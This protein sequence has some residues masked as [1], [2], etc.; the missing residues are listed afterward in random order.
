MKQEDMLLTIYLYVYLNSIWSCFCALINIQRSSTISTC[1]SKIVDWLINDDG[2]PP[3]MLP[4][5]FHEYLILDYETKLQIVT[6]A[7]AQSNHT[8][9]VVHITNPERIYDYA[10]YFI[11]PIDTWD[12]FIPQDAFFNLNSD[13]FPPPSPEVLAEDHLTDYEE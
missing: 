8:L 6:A 9:C 11:P 13:P 2:Q 5:L 10:Y 4:L 12:N 3:I 1:I 7:A